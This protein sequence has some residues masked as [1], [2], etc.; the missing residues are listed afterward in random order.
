MVSTDDEEI[1][2]IAKGAG[3]KVPFM[4]SEKTSNDYATTADVLMEVLET[5][6]EMGQEFAYTCCIYPTAPFVTAEKLTEAMK[7][8]L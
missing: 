1:A 6:K 2:R 3:A 4:R 8:V 5:Y 7:H